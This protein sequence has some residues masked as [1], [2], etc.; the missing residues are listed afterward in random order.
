MDHK[1]QESVFDEFAHRWAV[2]PCR[3]CK[4]EANW[5]IAS[6][7]RE[8]R[9]K[10]IHRAG[11]EDRWVPRRSRRGRPLGPTAPA[12]AYKRNAVILRRRSVHRKSSSSSSLRV[13]PPAKIYVCGPPIKSATHEPSQSGT[14]RTLQS[15]LLRICGLLVFC[16]PVLVFALT[17]MI[18]GKRELEVDKGK[19]SST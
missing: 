10:S 7:W 3:S 17:G 8:C 6:A 13:A 16:F 1:A 2:C 12:S 19:R 4:R 5:N 15:S 18:V 11:E 9:L 14:L